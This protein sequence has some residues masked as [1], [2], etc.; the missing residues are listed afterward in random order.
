M[1]TCKLG[2][3]Q[4]KGNIRTKLHRLRYCAL[5]FECSEHLCEQ[6]KKITWVVAGLL[7]WCK[8]RVQTNSVGKIFFRNHQDIDDITVSVGLESG[9]GLAGS[10]SSGSLTGCSQSVS[11]GCG[12]LRA[13]LG[14]DP[15]PRSLLWPLESCVLCVLLV[16]GLQFFTG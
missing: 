7:H 8:S 9:W 1:C 3:G 10:F 5:Y 16:W 13:Q 12:R 6:M 11:Y 2:S 4:K 14:E 15:F